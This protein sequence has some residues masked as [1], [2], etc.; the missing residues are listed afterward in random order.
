M[1]IKLLSKTGIVLGSVLVGLFL[2]FLLLPFV[3]NFFIDKYTP[4]I[5]GEINKATGLSAGLEDVKIVT[6]PKL[7]AGLKV[8]KFEL[9]TPKKEPVFIADDFE[10]KMSLLSI[11][12]KNIQI[13]VIRLNNADITLK[14]NKDGDLDLIQYI[15]EAQEPSSETETAPIELPF[16]LKLSN[17]LPDIRIGEY[18]LTLTDGKDN[19]ILSGGKTDI[20]DFIFNKSVKIKG[21]GN[22]VLKGKEQFKYDINLFNK[23]MPDADLN[24]LVF[25]PKKDENKTAEPVKVDVI[26]I[27]KGLYDYKVS[28]NAVVDLKTSTESIDGKVKVDNVSIIDLQ[29]SD[30]NLLFKSNSIDIDT[31]LYTAKNEVSKLS[32]KITTGKKPFVDMKFKSDLEIANLMNIVKKVA[33][34]FN[35]QDLQTLTAN[36]KINADFNIKS[37][38]KTV[39]S[40]GYLKVPTAKLYYGLYKIGVDNISADV[41]LNN[42]NI[43]IKNAG[44]SILGQPLKLYGTLSSDAVADINLTADKLSLKGLLIAIGQAAIMKENPIYSGTVSLSANIKGKLDKINPVIK[45]DIAN[46]DLKNIP[47]DLRL[48]APSTIV[49]ITSDGKTFGGNAKS[50]NI[51]IINPMAKISIPNIKANISE[52]VIEITQTPATIEKIGVNISGKIKDYLT[53]NIGLDFVSTGDIKST[54]TGDMN[55]AKQTLNL[56]YATT[57]LSE[58][59]IPM[60]DKSKMSFKGKIYITGSM[61]NPIVSGTAAVP[62]ISIPEIPVVMKDMDIKLRD[63]ILHGSGTVKE[64]ASGGIK[65]QNLSSDFELKGMDFYLN[66]LKGTSFDGKVNGNIVYNLSNAKTKIEFKGS[67]LNAEKAIEGAAGIK[68]ALTGTLGFD[69]RLK[70]TVLD[71]NS[72]IKSMTG[73]L[74]FDIKKG[75]FGTIGKFEGLLGASNIINNYFL[76]NTVASITNATGLATTA[77]FDTLDGKMTFSQGWANLN[78]IKSAGPSLC[79]YVTGKFN[80]LNGSTNVVILGKLDAPMVAKLGVLGQL[81][82]NNILGDKAGNIFKILTTPPGGEKT[83][84][85]PALTNGSTNFQEFKVNFN[86]GVESKSSIKTFKWISDADLTNYDTQTIKDTA[87]SITDSFN[88]DINTTKEDWNKAVEQK[89]KEVEDAKAEFNKTK[90]DIKNSAQEF[91]N[92]WNSLKEQSSNQKQPAS[93]NTTPS[94]T[95]KTETPAAEQVPA[96]G[97]VKTETSTQTSAEGSASGGTTSGASAE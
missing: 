7:T 16:G 57:E 18:K 78:P 73:D 25:N 26:N 52:N 84:L 8:K 87:K 86:G 6:T 55:V 56:T 95:V 2:I 5:V 94:S 3:L 45:L 14:F 77:M 43:N 38:T 72:M 11:L 39:Q 51:Q 47:M 36:G 85:I 66:N 24:E 60:F 67:G 1:N 48:K 41:A 58:I 37:D 75:A 33:L 71:Y 40:S 59:I 50:S 89:K 81:T 82:A 10:V 92:L 31:N 32:G 46:I 13:D 70:L 42:N 12:A 63:T 90:E 54:L 17:H 15:P 30:I 93:T 44:F 20:T 76:K 91:K 4:Q 88:K 9:Y 69:T 53:E 22:F 68:K 97:E 23:I 79:Y 29:P 34:I 35:I 96:A 62:S 74:N 80:L 28:A 65:A 49:D 27:L 64:F 83:N 61:L 19:Y 21:A